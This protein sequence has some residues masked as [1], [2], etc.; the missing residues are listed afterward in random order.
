MKKFELENMVRGWFVGNF[1]PSVLKT[2][3]VEVGIK[4]Y[5]KGDY[6]ERHYHKVAI[7]ITAIIDGSAKMNGVTYVKGD[8][9]VIFPF[10]DTDF[11]AL[12]DTKNVVVKIPSSTNDK[13]LGKYGGKDD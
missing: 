5:K 11:E 9:I 13:Y 8:I 4:T 3:E 6:E 12:E 2:N 1:E 7:E 10:E